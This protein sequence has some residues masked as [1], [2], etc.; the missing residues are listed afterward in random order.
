MQTE[1]QQRAMYGTTVE[2]MEMEW[3]VSTT[4]ILSPAHYVGCILSDVQEAMSHGT[5]G[6]LESARQWTNKAKYYL[7]EKF[8][9][10]R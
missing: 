2:D 10:G 4:A 3:A 6:S 9:R 1:E 5:A 7:W 8:P